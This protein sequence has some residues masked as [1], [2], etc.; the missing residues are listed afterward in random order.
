MARAD[1]ALYEAKAMGRDR[2]SM[3]G[4]LHPASFASSRAL[5]GVAAQMRA[6]AAPP[7]TTAILSGVA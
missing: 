7:D 1:M 2:P 3:A 4:S 5:A 6:S